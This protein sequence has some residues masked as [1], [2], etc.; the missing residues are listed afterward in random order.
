MFVPLPVLIVAGVVVLLL[1][2]VAL[3]RGR[4][5][6]DLMAA[7]PPATRIVIAP[8]PGLSVML[9]P[10]IESQVL[11]YTRDGQL[12]SAIKLVREA[13]GL[14]LKEAKDL[15]DEMRRHDHSSR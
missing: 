2:M 5:Q 14:G 13:T 9:P 7:P 4:G 10:D 6:S 12:I 8:S 15:V 11:D 1:L 3:R